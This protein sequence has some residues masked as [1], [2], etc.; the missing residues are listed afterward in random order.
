MLHEEAKK[1]F[2]NKFES[3][4]NEKFYEFLLNYAKNKMTANED[5][6]NK[7]PKAEPVGTSPEIELLDY[8]SKFLILY[9]RENIETYLNIAKVF[10][11]AA[12]KVYNILLKK[13]II[14]KSSKFLNLV[15]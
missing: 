1:I 4:G 15:D 8:Y 11:K 3:F 2:I 13:Q 6:K 7:N 10:R 5:I 14:E 12:Q 9:R